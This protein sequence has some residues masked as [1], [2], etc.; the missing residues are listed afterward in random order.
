MGHGEVRYKPIKYYCKLH[1]EQTNMYI[2]SQNVLMCCRVIFQLR[3]CHTNNIAADIMFIHFVIFSYLI[4]V[5]TL[6]LLFGL[7][8]RSL[9]G[10]YIFQ[11]RSPYSKLLSLDI[12]D[13]ARLSSFKDNL[14]CSRA[15]TL[16]SKIAFRTAAYKSL[17]DI[18]KYLFKS[19]TNLR[20]RE[21]KISMERTALHELNFAK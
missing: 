12:V 14:S 3:I 11:L 16:F 21:Y 19:T 4:A 7:P 18:V 20:I 17:L 6:P 5:H 1:V 2:W 15:S 9:R 13:A 10:T 8:P